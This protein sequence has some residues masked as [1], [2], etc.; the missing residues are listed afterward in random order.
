MTQARSGAAAVQLTDKRILITGGTD[1][2]GVP[3]AAVE[4]F[5]PATGVFTALPAMNVPRANHAAVVLESGDVLVTGGL[6]TGG[7]YSDSAEI[8]SITSGKWTLLSSPIGTGLEG[9][10]MV[11]L[12]DGNVLIA[13]GTST[14]K[15]VSSLVL[16]NKSDETFTSIGT[17]LTART[18]AAAAA[19]TGWPRSNCGR[20]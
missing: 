4:A 3:Q 9:Q 11:L 18:N 8:Y 7:S 6:T 20:Q 17:L 10:A 16:F 5:N 2:S 13:G 14:T 12:G 1:G 19:T 15:V